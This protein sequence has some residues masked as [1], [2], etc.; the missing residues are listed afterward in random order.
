MNAAAAN[1][2][3]A[4]DDPSAQAKA[5][6]EA[7][8]RALR[9]A[10]VTAARNGHPEALNGRSA[11]KPPKEAVGGSCP[12]CGTPYGKIRRCFRCKPT[13]PGGS[14]PAPAPDPKPKAETKAPPATPR[15]DHPWRQ[16]R[17][18]G[19]QGEPETATEIVPAEAPRAQARTA[20]TAP[21]IAAMDSVLAELDAMRVLAV[22][23]GPLD[24]AARTRVL[25][26]AWDRFA[27]G[28]VA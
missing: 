16:D 17:T 23:L 26:W 9:D 6:I 13:R 20:W 21:A 18:L 14:A 2:T 3:A 11:R 8:Y 25:A 1:G 22:A 7:R 24:E 19:P 15:P 10:K 12:D 28:G 27:E 5:E 4:L